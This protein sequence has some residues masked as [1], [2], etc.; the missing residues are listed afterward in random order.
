MLTFFKFDSKPISFEINAIK[1]KIKVGSRKTNL[2]KLNSFNP[3][4]K[5]LKLKKASNK[6]IDRKSRNI[7]RVF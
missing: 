1:I 4:G 7:N 3:L 6:A 5:L 2:E